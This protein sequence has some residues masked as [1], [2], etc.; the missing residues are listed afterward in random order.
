MSGDS[1]LDVDTLAFQKSFESQHSD[2][3]ND[4]GTEDIALNLPF[5]L[6]ELNRCLAARSGSA[7]GMDRL[8]Y[9]M[10]K[11]MSGTAL[12]IVLD[13]LNTVWARGVLPDSWK[14]ALVIPIP[15]ANKPVNDRKSYRPISLTSHLCKLMEGMINDRL[16]LHL[17]RNGI[18][19][20]FQS[21][22]RKG[23]STLDQLLRLQHDIK[24]SQ[25]KSEYVLAVQKC[26]RSS[27]A[28][29]FALQA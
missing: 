26:F 10:L 27:L 12:N 5:T 21:G 22:F 14:E 29:G 15:K 25:M 11:N 18:L 13:L 9:L 6:D 19:S 3:L 17:E 1:N 8:S 2:Y 23:R 4:P 28:R 20:P 24:K 16:G 7:P